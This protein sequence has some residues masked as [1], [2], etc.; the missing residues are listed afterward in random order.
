MARKDKVSESTSTVEASAPEQDVGF[1]QADVGHEMEL[2]LDPGPVKKIVFEGSPVEETPPPATEPEAPPAAADDSYRMARATRSDESFHAIRSQVDQ[3]G[4]PSP[5]FEGA[6]RRAVFNTWRSSSTV[7]RTE[8]GGEV[9]AYEGPSGRTFT[10]ADGNQERRFTEAEV[11]RV[12]ANV[13][14]PSQGVQ[15]TQPE[16][17]QQ[18]VKEKK[19]FLGGLLRKKKSVAE[20]ES[21][22]EAQ[23]E[24]QPQCSA[25]TEEGHQCR[26]S[27]RGGSKYCS[28]HAGYQPRTVH[29]I[30][31]GLDTE[32]RFE[33]TEN[34][35][36]GAMGWDPEQATA[37]CKALTKAGKQCTNPSMAHSMYCG[38]HQD[39]EA[40][41]KSEILDV[42][43]TKPRWPQAKD[44]KPAHRKMAKKSKKLKK[45][46]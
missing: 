18:P 32:P 26:N 38:V 40:L 20:S 12:I 31:A 7:Y 30:H 42:T 34:T 4:S 8:Q 1:S 15:E 43:D 45:G 35:V 46:K 44:T 25:L 33:S 27:A 29:G 17:V 36:P 37:Q 10:L 21:P 23:K 39:A 24:Y 11:D 9:R 41:T 16:P 5:A 28:S 19:G 2:V 6:P 14:L 13:R 22:V 3:L